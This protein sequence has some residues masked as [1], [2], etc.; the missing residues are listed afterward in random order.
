MAKKKDDFVGSLIRDLEMIK[1]ST[2]LIGILLDT[3]GN[4]G[5]RARFYL[6]I[7]EIQHLQLGKVLEFEDR[8]KQ[9]ETAIDE[10]ISALQIDENNV[11][12][13]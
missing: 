1:Q 3:A 2:W 7:D 13:E 9:L 10:T 4:D 6:Q 12:Q 11:Q 8:M 5:V